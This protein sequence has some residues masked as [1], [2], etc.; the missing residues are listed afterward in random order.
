MKFT[1]MHVLSKFCHVG[2]VSERLKLCEKITSFN[3][4]FLVVLVLI[5]P[6]PCMHNLLLYFT[7]DTGHYHKLLISLKKE[8]H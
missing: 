1:N 6:F 3:L 4:V 2:I 7:D 8:L 5:E